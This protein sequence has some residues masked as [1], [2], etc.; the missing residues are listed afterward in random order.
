MATQD[1]QSNERLVE[2]LA[3]KTAEV[4]VLKHIALNINSTL[5]LDQI[6]DLVLGTMDEFFGFRHSIILLLEDSD[7]LRV[8]ASHG[9]ENQPLGGTVPV[10]TGVIGTVAKRRR[11]MRVNNLR[12]QRAYFSTIRRRMEEDGRAS[13][14]GKIVP[15]HGLPDAESQIAIPLMIKDRLIGV[16]SVESREQRTFSDDDEALA[17]IVA[18]LAA[19]AIQNARLYRLVE[20]RRSELAEAH[21]HLKQLNETLEDRVSARTRELEQTNRELRETQVQLVQSGKMASLGMLAAGIAHEINTPI[22]AIHSNADVERRAIGVI[23]DVLQDPAFPEK[24]RDQPRLK[25]T[26]KIFDDINRV[27]LEATERVIKVIQSLKSF[28]RL[29]EPEL[30][31]VNLHEGLDSTLTLI[32]HL[33]KD[34]IEVVRNYGELPKVQC[35][36]SQINQ[37]FVNLLTNAAQAIKETGTITITTH[38]DGA[39]AV[40][41]V[42][43]TGG[44]IKPE[45]LDRIFDPGFTTKGVSV[46]LGLGL[47]ITYRII[48][49]HR[50]SIDVRS[51]LGKGTILTVRLPMAPPRSYLAEDQTVTV[52]L[53]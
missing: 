13:E 44:G 24:L 40:I 53:G 30:E 49:N 52:P 34:R 9:H 8:V 31:L 25:H 21:D 28:A 6:Y 29:D 48:E 35:Y 51:E 43:D 26:F 33:T 18:N 20:E 38:Q 11:L 22:G 41:E 50:G 4:H 17:T 10:G 32:N 46:G 36:A 45:H 47:S 39:C 42:A 1:I 15:V 7:T 37:V 3:Q 14:L 19:S 12:P 23:R 2:K 5:D 16:F 27:T